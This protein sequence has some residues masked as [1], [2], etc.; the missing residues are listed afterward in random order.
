MQLVILATFFN[1]NSYYLEK[2]LIDLVILESGTASTIFEAVVSILKDKGIPVKSSLVLVLIYG[3]L[4][5]V[6][7]IR[8]Q[9]F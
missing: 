8:W 7:I 4:G 3:M 6:K 9:N 2:A 5:S 1:E